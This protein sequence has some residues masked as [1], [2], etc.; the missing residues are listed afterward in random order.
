[1]KIACLSFVTFLFAAPSFADVPLPVRETGQGETVSTFMGL[2]VEGQTTD[3]RDR[4]ERVRESGW[5]VYYEEQ[6]IDD[7]TQQLTSYEASASS[8]PGDKCGL[9]LTL[10]ARENEALRCEVVVSQFCRRGEDNSSIRES[11]LAGLSQDD[12][13][14]LDPVSTADENRRLRDHQHKVYRSGG[15][16]GPLVRLA[17]TGGTLYLS[18]TAIL[19]GE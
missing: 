9:H 8:R 18:S 1:M 14:K 2:C 4:I 13:L 3:Y 12:D 16:S 17:D 6:A 7:V 10:E 19:R 5:T 15:G 11:V